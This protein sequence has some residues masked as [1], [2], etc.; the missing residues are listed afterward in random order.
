MYLCN[1][2]WNT[3]DQTYRTHRFGMPPTFLYPLSPPCYYCLLM[4]N[5]VEQVVFMEH[6]DRV[7]SGGRDSTIRIWRVRDGAQI[8]V[9]N[10]AHS[11]WV[12]TAL[13]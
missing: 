11:S 8:H 5:Q 12:Y 4:N 9:I 2:N 7:I 3:K 10:N 6:E 1:T 13:K